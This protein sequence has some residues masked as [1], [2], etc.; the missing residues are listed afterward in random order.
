MA[1]LSQIYL[2]LFNFV[3][4]SLQKWLDDKGNRTRLGVR[5]DYIIVRA[6]DRAAVTKFKIMK[7]NS[8]G[9]L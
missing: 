9:F 4:V 5:I 6:V 7:I 2:M 3:Q 1:S 8:E